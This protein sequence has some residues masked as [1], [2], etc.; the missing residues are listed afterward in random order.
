[1]ET[2]GHNSIP[3]L[4]EYKQYWNQRAAHDALIKEKLRAKAFKTTK[5]LAEILVK[6][7]SVKK[8]VLY[9]SD[10]KKGAFNEDSDIDIAVEGQSE[11][12]RYAQ[13]RNRRAG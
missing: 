10:L 9:G 11:R 12:I 1:M 6:E 13:E 2:E 8:I 7:F 4:A 5:K 3:T